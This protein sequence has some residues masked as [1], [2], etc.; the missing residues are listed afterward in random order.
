[1]F[2]L[3]LYDFSG[4][5]PKPYAD[6]GYDVYL[7]DLKHG[8]DVLKIDEQYLDSLARKS[9]ECRAVLAAPP[10]TDFSI[11]GAQYWKAKDA[12]GRTT[13]SKALVRAALDIIAYIRPPTWALENPVG[14]L[15][16]LFPVLR[17]FGPWYFDPCDCGGYMKPGE[18]SYDHPLVPP[19]DAYTKKTGIW[20]LFEMPEPKP[21]KPVFKIASNKD[22]Y[23]PIHMGTGGKSEKIK[24]IRSITPLGFAR[25]FYLANP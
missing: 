9:G 25:A 20:G 21:V 8:V 2:V 19:R 15:N 12:D 17:N 18:K 10:C 11:S 22:R 5:W 6:A 1:M 23:S 7:A 14:R 3:S 4:N 16:T 24:Q 13:E